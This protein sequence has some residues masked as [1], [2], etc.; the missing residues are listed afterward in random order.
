ME[1]RDQPGEIEQRCANGRPCEEEVLPRLRAA[2]LAEYV[3]G[4][5][6]AAERLRGKAREFAELHHYGMD[7]GEL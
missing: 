3:L 6:D 1:H 2:D 5:R 7:S 4:E